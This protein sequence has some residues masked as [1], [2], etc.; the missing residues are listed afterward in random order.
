[1]KNL[2]P[3]LFAL[4]LL[5]CKKKKE[6]VQESLIITAMTN[7]QWK[8]TTITVNGIDKSA[9]FYPYKFQFKTNQTVD[10]INAGSVEKTGSWNASPENQTITS[11]FS[12]STQP[13]IWL[14]GTWKITS[15]TWTS[16][17]ASIDSQGDNRTLRLD[18]L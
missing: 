13:L 11:S 6:E 2:Y 16:V 17:N 3:L 7:G 1:M 10:A 12:L 9:D 15:T 18:K 14:N 8:V 4:V 5:S